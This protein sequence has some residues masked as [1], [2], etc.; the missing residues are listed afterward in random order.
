MSTD[1]AAQKFFLVNGSCS[2][3][4]HYYSVFIGGKMLVGLTA[5]QETGC[6]T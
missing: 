4:G 1:L 6:E 3:V 2:L 5:H